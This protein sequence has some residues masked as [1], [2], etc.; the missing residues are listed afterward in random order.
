VLREGEGWSKNAINLGNIINTPYTER[1]PF[2][3]PDGKTLYF[4][5]DGH[6]GIGKSDVFKSVRLSDSSWTM[7]SEPVNLGKE[8]NTAEE[9]W[10]YKISTDGNIAYFST[11]ND[12]GFGE[13]DIYYINLPKIAKPV[14]DVITITG[15]VIDEEG[16]PVDA[17]IRWEDIDILKEVGVAKTDPETG[18]YFI[19]LPVGKHYA[20]YADVKGYYSTV[21]YLDLTAAKAFQEMKTDVQIISIE[22]LKKT[23][24]SIR[25]E[26]I[27]FDFD[28]FELKETSYEAL[29]LLFKFMTMN[30]E[31]KVEI[32]A[33][34]DNVGSDKYNQ[35]LSEKRAGAV[36]EYLVQKGINSSRLILHGYGEEFPVADNDT[37]EGRALN[38]RVEFRIVNSL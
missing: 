23:G 29:N 11:V 6:S 12:I 10:G 21:N 7:W 16:K 35:Q 32:N 30:P 3:H 26:N 8:V 33:Y 28:R 25:I 5:S 1:S 18:E 34:T 2:L 9:D 19:A 36:V 22:S 27:F 38:R 4:S 15:K 37:E 20:Y 14:S 31:I 17:N 24:R 13:E